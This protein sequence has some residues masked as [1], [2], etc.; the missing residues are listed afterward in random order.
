MVNIKEKRIEKLIEEL[1]SLRYGER[2]PLDAI[3]TKDTTPIPYED[4]ESRIFQ[5]IEVGTKWGELWDSSWFKLSGKVPGH[6]KGKAVAALIDIGGEGCLF[7]DGS[8]YCGIT[9]KRTETLFERKRRIMLYDV[10][11]GG[12]EVSLLI[13]G[14]ANGLFG[15]KPPWN[16]AWPFFQLNQAEL[17]FLNEEIWT[18]AMDMDFLLQVYKTL[19]PNLPRA[20]RILHGLNRAAN[21]TPLRENVSEALKITKD[22]IQTPSSTSELTAWSVGH[23]HIDLAWLWRYRE[24]RRKAGRTF[25]TALRMME[26]YP[27]YIFGASQP[28]LFEWVKEDYPKVY[29]EVKEAV[30]SGRMEC[31]GGMWV[32]PDMNLTGG[33]SLVRQCLYGKRFFKEEF[34]LEI[35]NLWLPDVFGYSAALP[36]ILK[37]SGIDYFMTQKISW[38][39]TNTFPHHTFMWAGIDGTEVQTHFLPTNNYNCA[40]EPQRMTEANL[41]FAQSDIHEGYLNLYGIGDGGGGPSRRHIEWALRGQDCEGMPKIKMAKAQQ[42]FQYLAE[43]GTADLPRWRGELYLEMHRGTY[44]THALIKKY[45]RQLELKLRDVELLGTLVKCIAKG[46]YPAERIERIWKD[47]LLNQFHDVL[48]GSSI[49]E[50]YEDAEKIS[51]ENLKSLAAIEK[52]FL[53]QLFSHEVGDSI[54]LFNT[55]PWKRTELVCIE[56]KDIS[57]TV[58]SMGYASFSKEELKL[59][60]SKDEKVTISEDGSLLEN[61]FLRIEIKDDGIIKSILLKETGQEMLKPEG[62][63]IFKLYE[64]KPYTFDAWDISPYYT[65]TIPET[66]LLKSQKILKKTRLVIQIEQVYRI[67]LSEIKQ[68][69]ELR[70]GESLL[71]AHCIVEWNE[72]NKMLRVSAE[73]DISWPTATYEIQYGSIE[74]PTHSNTSWDEAKFEVCGHRFADLSQPDRG[75]ALLNDCKYGYRIYDSVM[76]LNLLRSPLFPDA[77]ADRGHHEF[78]YAYMPHSGMLKDSD[79]IKTSHNFNTPLLILDGRVREE[80]KTYSWFS[81]DSDQVCIDVVK[82]VEDGEGVVVRCYEIKGGS[83]RCRLSSDLPI[84]QVYS[85]NLLEKV[86]ELLAVE[87][88]NNFILEFKPFEIKTLLLL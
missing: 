3:F 19:D 35:N 46:E 66:A 62:A 53:H 34:G 81:S 69:L 11:E 57:V 79:V 83:C 51:E 82:P 70:S 40:N 14:A 18:L 15:D 58:P 39:E 21:L 25:S 50:V 73:T 28:Q 32:E 17:A 13:E 30:K 47:T 27:E 76:E 22:L 48:P 87:K 29:N 5:K 26:E 60:E 12:E 68:V 80:E 88:P 86:D 2:V 54:T 65:E 55:Q 85:V 20:K 67:G 45:N 31:Q 6:W 33:E 64:D 78:S 72:T 77:E 9:Y 42:Y 71:R 36:Q 59:L 74:R 16:T 61:E 41:R 63:G 52:T 10:A 4:I 1:Y 8:P 56:G 23:A 24:T 84:N 43:K 37:K 7:K 38:N 44:T 49:K 75:I